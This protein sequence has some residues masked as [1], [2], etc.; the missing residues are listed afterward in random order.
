MTMPSKSSLIVSP[1]T[2]LRMTGPPNYVESTTMKT[3]L[4]DHENWTPH[5]ISSY[6]DEPPTD[7]QAEDDQW[8]ASVA[9][10]LEHQAHQPVRV[11]KLGA[12]LTPN[13][14]H[15]VTSYAETPL[16]KDSEANDPDW[17]PPQ[18]STTPST[19]TPATASKWD[20]LTPEQH[21]Q[22]SYS[23]QHHSV[24]SHAH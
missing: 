11:I 14:P 8:C 23:S 6:G 1:A 7:P 15:Y 13:I 16:S 4:S 18:S 10:A 22:L 17:T 21:H 3:P 24:H 12:G 9:L 2:F 5:T 20:T 19:L